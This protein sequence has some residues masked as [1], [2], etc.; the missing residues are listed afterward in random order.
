MVMGA[1]RTTTTFFELPFE[2]PGLFALPFE[3]DLS[4]EPS[5]LSFFWGTEKLTEFVELEAFLDALASLD[6]K[7]SVGE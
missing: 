4:R 5:K 2:L 1:D 7:L 3:P 6:F